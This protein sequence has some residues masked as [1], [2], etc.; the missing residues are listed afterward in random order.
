MAPAPATDVRE[1][2]GGRDSAAKR[3]YVRRM[4]AAIAPRY[5]LLN[6]LLSLNVDRRWRRAAVARLG[7]EVRPAGR[8][9]DVASGTMD[10]AAELARAPGFA[11]SVIGAD[12]VLPMLVRGRHKADRAAPVAADALS[13][14]FPD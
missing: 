7:W 6:H 5:D 8:Y 9:L 2:V 3:E 10:L 1:A 13:L 14:P 4:F 11:G 12:F